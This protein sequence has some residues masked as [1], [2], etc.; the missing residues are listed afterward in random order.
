MAWN[1]AL[2]WRFC[3]K[4]AEL[5]RRLSIKIVNNAPVFIAIN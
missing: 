3:K 1:L 5:C 2:S 4:H